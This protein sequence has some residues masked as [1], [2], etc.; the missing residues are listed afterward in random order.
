M[1]HFCFASAKVLHFFRSTKSFAA[2][3]VKTCHF[4]V[5]YDAIVSKTGLYELVTFAIVA[6]CRTDGC[7][8]V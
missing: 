7:A 2:F 4:I 8:E 1:H 3:F 5:F 6:E